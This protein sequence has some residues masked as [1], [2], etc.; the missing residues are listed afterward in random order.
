MLF[1]K[2]MYRAHTVVFSYFTAQ[3]RLSYDAHFQIL[4]CD[5]LTQIILGEVC[6]SE[7]SCYIARSFTCF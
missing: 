2:H 4:I 7:G 3:S 6:K 1:S 5:V